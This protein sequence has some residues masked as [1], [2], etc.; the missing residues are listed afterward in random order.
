MLVFF[1]EFAQNWR[2]VVLEKVFLHIWMMSYTIL[3]GLDLCMI[4]TQKARD[5]CSLKGVF[6]PV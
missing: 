6:I 1:M 4:L 3:F 5:T 2:S